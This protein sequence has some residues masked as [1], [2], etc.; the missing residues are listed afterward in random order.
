MPSGVISGWLK[1]RGGGRSF[2]LGSTKYQPRWFVLDSEGTVRY[3]KAQPKKPNDAPQG[4]FS[5]EGAEVRATSATDFEVAV[6]SSI[7]GQAGAPLSQQER[8]FYLRAE[9]T[10]SRDRWLATLQ[11]AEQHTAAARGAQ[12]LDV[13]GSAHVVA[14]ALVAAT[15]EFALVAKERDDR[16]DRATLASALAEGG[17]SGR[18]GALDLSTVVTAALGNAMVAV[19]RRGAIS[20]GTRVMLEVGASVLA[21]RST[22][23]KGG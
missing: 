6:Q 12:S 17:V 1:K 16:L 19:Q 5:S 23:K 2:V 7:E 21:V 22:L 10:E 18:I 9:S 20:E 8:V 15:V 13:D 3:Y 11:T 14:C 4:R